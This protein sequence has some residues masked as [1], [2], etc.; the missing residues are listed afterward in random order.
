MKINHRIDNIDKERS[1]YFT[2]NN[3]LN[4]RHWL[5]IFLLY[6]I[7]SLLYDFPIFIGQKS[8]FNRINKVMLRKNYWNIYKN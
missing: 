3:V 5:S 1:K 6:L 2:K 7:F 4:K 8:W